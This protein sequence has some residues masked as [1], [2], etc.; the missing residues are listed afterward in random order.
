[1]TIL[2]KIVTYKKQEVAESKNRLPIE[3]LRDGTYYDREVSSLKQRILSTDQ[4]HIIAEFKRQSPSAGIINDKSLVAE[5][6]KGYEDCKA[7]ACSVLTDHPSFGGS[8]NDLEI[9]RI[10]CNLP[11]LRK[12][13]MIDEYQFT[14]AKANGA[15]LVLLIASILSVDQCKEF[16]HIAKS[17]G[18]EVLLEIH[19][20]EELNHIN[21]HVDFVGVNNR[22][23]GTFKVSIDHSKRLA[24]LI[25]SDKIKISES[26][27][28]SP[29]SCLE[30]YKHG[31][32]AFLIGGHFMANSNPPAALRK[33]S[34]S[35]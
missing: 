24:P 21:E 1:M 3:L 14:E 26:G 17:L 9:A 22:D 13:F 19:K 34:A 2:D 31:F 11:L 25:P 27:L 29:Q 18:L 23:L 35:L 33:F 20:E 12:D 30:L 32:Q 5:V 10:S 16:A 15:D 4:I 8:L 6:I 7:S 28:S